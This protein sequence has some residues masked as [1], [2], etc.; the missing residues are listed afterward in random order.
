MPKTDPLAQS[1]DTLAAQAV[2]GDE[3]ARS[4]LLTDLRVRFLQVAKRRLQE[5]DCEDVVQEA[6]QIVLL[7]YAERQ[8]QQNILV[9]SFAVLRNVIGNYY[10][11]RKRQMRNEPYEERIHSAASAERGTDDLVA[12][13]EVF[14]GLKKAL[15]TLAHEEPRCGR[16]FQIVL[17]S[18]DEGGTP[19]EINRR[20]MKRMR[21]KYDRMTQGALYVALHRCRRRLKEIVSSLEG[22]GT[23]AGAPLS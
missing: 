23:A 19:V 22:E 10:Q 4:A 6:L 15:T 1:L 5:D 14:A 17:E 20:A 8:P 3:I 2:S 21:V 9:W 7:R 18:C 11:R 12:T 13:K 16:L